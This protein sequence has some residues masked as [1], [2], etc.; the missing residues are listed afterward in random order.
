MNLGNQINDQEELLIKRTTHLVKTYML[1]PQFD[2]SHDFAHVQ[3]VLA[4]SQHILEAERRSNPAKTYNTTLVVL[5]AL[6]HD[7]DDKKYIALSKQCS[8]NDNKTPQAEQML[9]D[10]ECPRA[11]AVSVQ[12][13]IA[14]VSYT[15]EV[16]RPGLIK[17]TLRDYPEL[18][19]VQDADRLDALGAVGVARAFAY[20]G[21]KQR[22]RGLEETMLH[23]DEKLLHLGNMMKTQEGRRLASIK[24][25]RLQKFKEWWQD[26]TTN[27]AMT[28][29]ITTN[30]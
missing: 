8:S 20:G 6:L 27:L 11:T 25:E 29:T 30:V 4:L 21:A 16:N 14:A 24:I 18:A 12:R 13:I 1:Q 7:V 26:E 17:E 19:I 15:T 2:A 9:L 3:R 22:H 23:F 28:A 5:A 10:L